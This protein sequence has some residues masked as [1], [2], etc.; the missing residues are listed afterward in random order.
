MLNKKEKLAIVDGNALIH[1][2]FH[3]IPPLTSKDG[4]IVNAVYGFFDNFFQSYVRY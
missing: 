3:A 4:L 1:R 2:A